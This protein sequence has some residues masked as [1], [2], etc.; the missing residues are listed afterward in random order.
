MA[1]PKRSVFAV[2]KDNVLCVKVAAVM[3]PICALIDGLTLVF[4]GKGKTAYLRV[5]DAIACCRD[6]AK[7]HSPDKYKRLP[8]PPTEFDENISS[9]VPTPAL[10]AGDRG[11]ACRPNRRIDQD[12][13]NRR[14]TPRVMPPLSCHYPIAPAS[15]APPRE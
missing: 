3:S 9:E 2:G 15:S 12:L 14:Q 6:E 4:F 8:V 1:K 13:I 7:Y 10:V 5:T 11:R